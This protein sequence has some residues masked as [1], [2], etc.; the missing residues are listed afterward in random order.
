MDELL[1]GIDIGT[2]STKG[3]LTS[4]DGEVLA[5]ATRQHDMSLPRPGWAEVDADEVWWGDVVE[6]CR[7]LVPQAPGQEIAGMCVS[8]VGPCL[9]LCDDDLQPLRPAIL[10]GIDMRADVE[11][12]ELNERFGAEELLARCGKA[13]SSQAVG[14]KMVWVQ[15]HEPDVWKRAHGWYNANTFV[16]ARLTGS[17]FID[18]HTASQCDPLYDVQAHDWARDWAEEVAPD[19]ALPELVWPHEVVGTV[20]DDAAADTGVP[21]G[22]PVSA[23]TIDAWSEAFSVGVRKPGDLMVMYGST[24]FFV[25]V[26]EAFRVHQKL[27]TTAGVEPG[28]HTFAAG[29]ATSGSVTRWLSELVGVGFDQLADE[30]GAIEPGSDGLV[31]LPYFAGERTPIFDRRARGLIAGLTLRHE[32]GHLFRAVYEGIAYGARQILELMDHDGDGPARL[33]AVGGGTTGGLWTQVVSD[34]TGRP[35]EVPAVRVGASFGDALLAAIGTGLVPPGTD[36][37]VIDHRVEPDMGR[38]E[39]YDGLFATFERL[40][41]ATRE[42][43]H[44]LADI[45]EAG[46]GLGSTPG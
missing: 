33:V 26:L 45:Q 35:Q 46:D 22:T 34:V 19:I 42:Q 12:D 30:A 10:Y 5:V 32:R 31:V 36:W 1:L 37:T 41:P 24:M 6:L 7:E 38:R 13:L 20:T 9:L 28:S 21:A 2:A 44:L 17:Y 23:G 25:Q 14:P 15:R 8:G 11:I 43:M 3:V 29:M 39:R 27:W 16:A 40:Y 18:H 4:P